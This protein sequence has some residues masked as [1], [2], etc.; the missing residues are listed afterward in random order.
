[1]RKHLFLHLHQPSETWKIQLAEE[2][3]VQIQHQ[4]L[5]AVFWVF[6]L[7]HNQ[8]SLHIYDMEPWLIQ[9]QVKPSNF[10]HEVGAASSACPTWY[11]TNSLQV[12]EYE[13]RCSWWDVLKAAMTTRLPLPGNWLKKSF[14]ICPTEIRPHHSSYRSLLSFLM[15]AQRCSVPHPPPWQR[16]D[17]DEENKDDEG[18]DKDED[19]EVN[20]DNE[21]AV[22]EEGEDATKTMKRKKNNLKIHRRI[23]VVIGIKI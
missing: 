4:F 12:P 21:E 16:D 17:E 20:K 10:I 3:S 14:H 18:K 7:L 13:M 22:D 11:Q 6:L 5:W 2:A 23:R 9:S 15:H 8:S 1:M 19:K